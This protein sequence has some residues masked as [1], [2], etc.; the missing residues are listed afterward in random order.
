M[1]PQGRAWEDPVEK[2]LR[3]ERRRQQV[4][5][6]LKLPQVTRGWGHDRQFRGCKQGPT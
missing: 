1:D 3:H 6:K 2:Q 5:L 4:R